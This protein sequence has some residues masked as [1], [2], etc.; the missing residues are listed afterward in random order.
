MYAFLSS[1]V[2]DFFLPSEDRTERCFPPRP[3]MSDM[4]ILPQTHVLCSAI[5][6]KSL[7]QW[8]SLVEVKFQTWCISLKARNNH[9]RKYLMRRVSVIH[10]GICKRSRCIIYTKEG[11]LLCSKPFSPDKVCTDAMLHTEV[12]FLQRNPIAHPIKKTIKFKDCLKNI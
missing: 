3:S 8:N 6:C 1:S 2:W 5:L 10:V 9:A 11:T 7:R 4:I 12:Q